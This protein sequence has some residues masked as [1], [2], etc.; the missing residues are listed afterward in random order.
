VSQATSSSVAAPGARCSINLWDLALRGCVLE[1]G[2]DV[3]GPNEIVDEPLVSCR[4]QIVVRP[5]SR[6][7]PGLIAPLAAER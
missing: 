5:S 3:D 1:S 4:K 7:P 6:Q 2:A